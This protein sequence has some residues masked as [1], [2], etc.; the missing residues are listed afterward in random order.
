MSEE[1]CVD[2]ISDLNKLLPTPAECN[3]DIIPENLNSYFYE[4]S[5]YALKNNPD[6]HALLSCL[7]LLQS[8]RLQASK[9]LNMLIEKKKLA[10]EDPISFVTKL[11]KKDKSLKFPLPIEIAD[12]PNINW[13]KYTNRAS[14][15]FQNVD[16]SVMNCRNNSKMK[17][18]LSDLDVKPSLMVDDKRQLKAS[19]S[20]SQ[21]FNKPWSAEEQ[22]LLDALLVKYPPERF[23]SRRW[24][25]IAEELKTRTPQQVASRVQKYF[26]KLASQGLPIPGRQPT[27]ASG[28][29]KVFIYSIDFLDFNVHEVSTKMFFWIC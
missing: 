10:L 5:H 27:S 4:T 24:F 20:L 12:I 9:D 1:K 2:I 15:V 29:K 23:E 21:T 14:K 25:K 28:L 11:Q 3:A 26:L 13:S 16:S 17:L 22:R 19:K 7:S 6:Y 18:S 8:Q